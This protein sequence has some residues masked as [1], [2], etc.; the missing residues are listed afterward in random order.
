MLTDE[1]LLY[2]AEFLPAQD[3]LRFQSVSNHFAALDTDSIWKE[4]CKQ[5]WQPWPRYRLSERRQNALPN[6]SWKQRYLAIE[7]EAT[8]THL[9]MSDLQNSKWYLSFVLPGV[10]VREG[11]SEHIEVVFRANLLFVPGHHVPYRYEIVNEPPPALPN[12]IRA[13]LH[14]DRPFSNRQWLRIS[15]F[16]V[17]FVTRKASDAEWLIVNE[18]VIMVSCPLDEQT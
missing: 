13:T 7:R 15:T 1:L 2:I 5:R 17:H 12:H 18:N 14:G 3:L 11:R 10:R 8:R 16:P 6:T 4:R 9:R